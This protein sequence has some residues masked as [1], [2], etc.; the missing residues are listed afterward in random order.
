VRSSILS[1]ELRGTFS[2]AKR[3]F[4]RIASAVATIAD[5]MARGTLQEVVSHTR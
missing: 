3:Q 4:D 2:R 5:V 1:P